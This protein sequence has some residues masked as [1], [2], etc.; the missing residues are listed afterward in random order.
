VAISSICWAVT[1]TVSVRVLHRLLVGD[2]R[3]VQLLDPDDVDK[4]DGT[5]G[6]TIGIG[7]GD[8]EL[9]LLDARLLRVKDGDDEVGLVKGREGVLHNQFQLVQRMVDVVE[10]ALEA[11][12]GGLALRHGHRFRKIKGGRVVDV[13]DLEEPIVRD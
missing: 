5:Y 7:D 12:V 6:G 9:V 13:Y 4:D 2:A 11:Q 3:Q 1:T 8:Q 10:G